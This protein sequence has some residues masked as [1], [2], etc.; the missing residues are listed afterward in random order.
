M[1]NFIIYNMFSLYLYELFFNFYMWD[2]KILNIYFF[3]LFWVD[4]K[5][6]L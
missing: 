1:L 4:P 6:N 3:E 5:P 2:I